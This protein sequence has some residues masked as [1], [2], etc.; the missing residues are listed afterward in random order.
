MFSLKDF[1]MAPNEHLGD[2]LHSAYD[3]YL[4]L[5]RRLAQKVT[6]AL[7]HTQS[8]QMSL[9]LCPPCFYTLS[10]ED[11]LSPKL[12]SVMDGN[13]SLKLIDSSYRVGNTRPDD[14]LLPSPRWIEPQEV[15]EFKDDV[16]N[17]VSLSLNLFLI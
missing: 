3:V 4:D 17:R 8:D 7:G 15:D 11:K 12:L 1:Q 2:Q 6:A 13:N 9:L 16:R 10:K 5:Q 14:R